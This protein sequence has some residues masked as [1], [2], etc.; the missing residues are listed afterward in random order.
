M[1]TTKWTG[2]GTVIGLLG[3]PVLGGCDLVAGIGDFCEI[4]VDPGCGTGG[5]GSPGGGGAGPTSGGGGTGGASECSMAGME[6]ACYSGPDGTENVGVC[7]GGTRTC[8]SDGTWGPC[9]GE[10]VPGTETCTSTDD[11]DCDGTE[12]ALWSKIFGDANQQYPLDVAID[13]EGNI[14]VLGS[15]TGKI[16]LGGGEL[17]S[18]GG[19]D[20]FLAKF[21][22]EGRHLWSFRYGDSAVQYS[23]AMALDSMDNIILTGTYYGAIDFGG[24]PVAASPGNTDVFVV[25]LTPNGVPAW[26]KSYGDAAAQDAF[27][28]TVDSNDDVLVIGQF[29]GSMTL[30][31]TITA[32]GGSDMWVG[33]FDGSS[34]VPLGQIQIDDKANQ[35]SLSVGA[36]PDGTWAICGRHGD[37]ADIGGS[38]LGGLGSFVAKYGAD[39]MPLWS[40]HL[41]MNAPSSI[42][43]DASGDVVVAGT[44]LNSVNVGGMMFTSKGVTDALVAK[45]AAL[46]GAVKWVNAYGGDGTE[47]GP[48]LAADSKGD[49]FFAIGTNS[50]MIGLGGQEIPGKGLKDVFVAALNGDGSHRWSRG[51]GDATDQYEAKLGIDPQGKALMVAAYTN[52]TIDFGA[53]D[54]D[55]SGQDLALAKLAP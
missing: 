44:F 36:G 29:E 51:F 35:T 32:G 13:S 17:E 21:S 1:K 31:G 19:Y 12:C 25:K 9:D 23:A 50:S 30:K 15:F 20:L 48:R 8:Q 5:T 6:Q 34:G 14:L 33:R 45:L 22:A 42:S 41:E 18:A 39:D 47:L 24:I 4:G 55:S 40:V 54:L 7:A 49:I 26:A 53:G 27:D 11:E 16:D 37:G 3:T 46:D 52:G 38:T 10:I 43:T 28:V 2:W